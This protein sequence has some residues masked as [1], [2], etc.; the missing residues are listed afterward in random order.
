M[1][2]LQELKAPWLHQ[3][4]LGSLDS[5]NSYCF[6]SYWHIASHLKSSFVK[7]EVDNLKL[8]WYIFDSSLYIII[9]PHSLVT[10]PVQDKRVIFGFELSI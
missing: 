2:T 8:K 9:F 10:P 5:T 6:K 1:A 3:N 7:A 4:E